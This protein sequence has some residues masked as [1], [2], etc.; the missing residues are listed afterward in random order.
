M[1]DQFMETASDATEAVPAPLRAAL[2]VASMNWFPAAGSNP[3]ADQDPEGPLGDPHSIGIPALKY[4]AQQA[5]DYAA[6]Q[7][8][9]KYVVPKTQDENMMGRVLPQ[10]LS[11]IAKMQ[12]NYDWFYDAP[13]TPPRLKKQPLLPKDIWTEQTMPLERIFS[14]AINMISPMDVNP[15]EAGFLLRSYTGGLGSML[16]SGGDQL[17]TKL[18]V[19]FQR[20]TTPKDASDFPINKAFWSRE[21]WGSSSKP[22]REMYDEWNK[23][24]MVLNSLQ[25]NMMK[26]NAPR[27]IDIM[28]E[29]P[30][31][32]PGKLLE[33]GVEE[34]AQ[35]HDMRRI[36]LNSF[37]LP[38]EERADLLMQIDQAITRYA[39]DIM[40]AYNRIKRDPSITRRLLEGLP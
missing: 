9:A 8:L 21:P 33:K 30:E 40:M 14:Q 12:G 13:V 20:P 17:L 23:V 16:M 27:V 6:T 32:I 28:R 35:F 39:F 24:E 22:V 11:P 31:F 29:H 5:R 3:L 4:L 18:G 10:V 1:R 26:P 25:H 38:D 7:T 34:L 19:Q 2:G 37:Q 15:I 36:V